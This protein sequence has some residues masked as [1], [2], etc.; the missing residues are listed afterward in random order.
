MRFHQL[1]FVATVLVVA[2]CGPEE[3]SGETTGIP[4]TPDDKY[5]HAIRQAGLDGSAVV[6]DWVAAVD[7]WLEGA[8]P[9]FA[10][11]TQVGFF[12]PS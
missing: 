4:A 11:Y 1:A 10:P 8:L 5:V 12:D 9:I 3:D 2:G 7:R 6:R